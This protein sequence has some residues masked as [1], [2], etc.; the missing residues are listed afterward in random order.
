VRGVRADEQRHGF[1]LAETQRGARTRAGIRRG[2]MQTPL[3]PAIRSDV[4]PLA[5]HAVERAETLAVLGGAD[6]D[7]R[8]AVG[9]ARF[10]RFDLALPARRPRH[11]RVRGREIVGF[12]VLRQIDLESRRVPVEERGEKEVRGEHGCRSFQRRKQPRGVE[13]VPTGGQRERRET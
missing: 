9:G 12:D 4:Q 5:P 1:T 13:P 3:V 7:Q 2:R 6:H 8:R 10:E 11:R